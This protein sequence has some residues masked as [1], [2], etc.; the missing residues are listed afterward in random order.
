M[1]L[2]WMLALGWG[3]YLGYQH[4]RLIPFLGVTL[5]FAAVWVWFDRKHVD[6]SKARPALAFA[7]AYISVTLWSAGVMALAYWPVRLLHHISN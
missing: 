7:E 1:L 3:A 2:Q 6:T 4:T 5:A